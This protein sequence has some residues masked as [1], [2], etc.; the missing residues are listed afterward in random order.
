MRVLVAHNSYS[1]R[2]PS[3][4]NLAVADEVRW[5]REAGVEV[6]VHEASNDDLLAG[7][8]MQR[9]R[10]A[11]GVAW[12]GPARQAFEAVVEETTPDLVHVHN[13][14]PLLSASVP[15]AAAH[16]G[17]P[18]VW[19]VHNH[20]LL[21][22]NGTNF[23]EGAPCHLC[24]PGWRLPGIRH[25]CYADSAPASTLVTAATSL[26]RRIARRHVTAVAISDDVQRWLTTTAGF[27]PERV[28]RKY[29]GVAPPP[30]DQGPPPPAAANRVLLFAGHMSAH[31]GVE[32]LLDA[33]RR[34]ALPDDVELRFVG[35]GP[36]AGDVTRAG[37]HDP[38]I[39]WAGMAG[40]DEM[41][42]HLAAA[43]VVVV[44][45]TWDEPFGRGAAEALAYGRPVITSGR[46]G[47]SEVVDERS[48]WI[49]GTDPAV[50]AEALRTAAT[51]DEAVGDR[52]G[53]AR[54]RHQQLFSPEAT[55]RTLV[56]IYESLLRRSP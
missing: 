30:A 17:L 10:Q 2:V 40:P 24:R 28:V 53:V 19:T 8:A 41:T 23:R 48:G 5:L 25:G 51:S 27:A 3:G 18:V 4:E 55:T 29:N 36:L 15:W 42:S 34:A 26:F 43:R 45:S 44:P 35:D 1:S 9:A 46:G 16:R 32:L 22:V 50:L 39:T 6:V 20:R 47:L 21:C 56:G 7:G 13:L 33:W 11:L 12:S 54:Q 52:A 31:K 49:T 14:F 37:E 38:R